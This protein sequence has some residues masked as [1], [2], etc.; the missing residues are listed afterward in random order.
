MTHPSRIAVQVDQ[1]V[2][3]EF[4]KL[5]ALLEHAAEGVREYVLD[6]ALHLLSSDAIFDCSLA[7]GAGDYIL[8]LKLSAMWEKEVLASA[9]GALE[10]NG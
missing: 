2:Y 8:V 6:S 1:S 3:D 4:E 7:S 9:L 5:S 10:R